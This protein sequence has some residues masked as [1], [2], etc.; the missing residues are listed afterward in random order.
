MCE[1]LGLAT[2]PR[3]VTP[4][5]R[6]VMEIARVDTELIDWSATR[7]QQ[8]EAALEGITDK[9]V[10]DH[11]RL[12]GERGRHGL[13]WWAAQE[14]RP[15]KKTPKPLRELRVCWCISALLNFEHRAVDGLLQRCRAAGAVIRSRVRPLVG[16]AL[17]AV[18]VAAVVLTVRNFFARRYVLAEARRHLLETLRGRAFAP[19]LDDHITDS[20]LARHSRQLTVPSPAADPGIGPAHL[21]RRLHLARPLVDRRHRRQTAPGVDAVRAGPRSPASPCRTRTA[22]RKAGQTGRS[23]LAAETARRP[24]HHP[25]V[26]RNAAALIGAAR[27]L[28]WA[29]RR[30]LGLVARGCLGHRAAS[31][32]VSSGTRRGG[33][34]V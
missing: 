13:G 33:V 29:G 16:A 10:R 9:Y 27:G 8:I 18:D 30:G 7:R 25:P 11:G 17:A 6:P 14:T 12:P 3:E 24:V 2:V 15:E 20:A 28:V 4:C 5:L 19:G 21:H 31:Q 23:R 34:V 22:A 26:T 1:E 32:F